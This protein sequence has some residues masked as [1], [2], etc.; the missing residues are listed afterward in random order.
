[1]WCLRSPWPDPCSGPNPPGDAQPP[2]GA[3]LQGL[4]AAMVQRANH[5]FA[6]LFMEGTETS[7]LMRASVDDPQRLLRPPLDLHASRR[8]ATWPL[9]AFLSSSSPNSPELRDW[10]VT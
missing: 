5:A 1:M 6:T 2:S 7:C 10:V 3:N 9:V 8:A 4:C